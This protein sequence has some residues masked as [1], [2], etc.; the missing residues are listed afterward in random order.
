MFPVI[1]AHCHITWL[2]NAQVIFRKLAFKPAIGAEIDFHGSHLIPL[3]DIGID[4]QPHEHGADTVKEGIA[5]DLSGTLDVLK[6]TGLLRHPPGGASAVVKIDVHG[7]KVSCITESFLEYST[8]GRIWN[9]ASNLILNLVFLPKTDPPNLYELQEKQDEAPKR[10]A[11]I[12]KRIDK[13]ESGC[14]SNAK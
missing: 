10:T 2:H 13:I 6:P 11:F 4:F 1:K 12:V 3:L 7:Q 5:V 9:Q 8:L 14:Y